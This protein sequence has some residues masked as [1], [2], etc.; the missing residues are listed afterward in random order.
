V[1]HQANFCELTIGNG[2]VLCGNSPTPLF[3][4]W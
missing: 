4:F 2:K 3:S 1:T